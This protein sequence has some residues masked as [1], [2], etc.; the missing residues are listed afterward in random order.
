DHGKETSEPG[1]S[2]VTINLDG[3]A[4]ATTDANGNYTISSVGPGTH[5]LSE[6]IPSQYLLTSPANNAITI[7]A[8]SGTNVVRNF[9]NVQPSAT[10]DNGQTSYTES[11]TGWQTLSQ[12]WNGS[13]RTHASVSGTSTYATWTLTQSGGLPA[14]TYEFFVT[15]VAAAGRDATA[16]YEVDDSLTKRGT[17]EVNQTVAPSGGM[18]QGANLNS[19]GRVTINSRTAP[20]QPRL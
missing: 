17:D 11:G 10:S 6:V 8:R 13:S 16:T 2:G 18:Y 9:G 3:S 15:Y 12:G 5:T 4:A 1:I 14:G 20:L 19:L 7:T